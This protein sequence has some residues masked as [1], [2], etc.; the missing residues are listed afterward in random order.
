MG[1]NFFTICSL[2]YSTML[3]IIYFRRKNI[4]TLETS[5]YSKLVLINFMN[6]VLAILCYLTILMKD[7]LPF[8]NDLVSKSL[9][10]LFASWEFCFT[11]YL[12][13]ITRNQD[14]KLI[15]VTKKYKPILIVLAT[16]MI[17]VVFSLPLNYY[18]SNNIVYSYGPSANFIYGITA[19]L[20]VYWIITILRNFNILKSKKCIPVVL[21]IILALIAVAIQK[22][23]PGLLL[24]TAVETFITVLMF[25]TIENPDVKLLQELAKSKDI[26]DNANEEKTLFLYNITQEIRKAVNVVDD[27]ADLILMSEDVDEIRNSARELKNE[28]ARFTSKTNGIL[29]VSN[30]DSAN[31]KVYNSKYNIKLL[32]KEIVNLYEK[33]CINKNIEFRTSV[34]HNIPDMLLGDSINLKEVLMIVLDNS[35]KYTDS[36]YVELDI[37]TIIKKDVCRLIITIEDS[38]HGIKSED[39][40][41]YKVSNSSLSKAN[42]LITLMNGTMMILSDY[43]RGTRVKI[44]LDQKIENVELD[45]VNKYNSFFENIKIL[46]VDDSDASIK[47]VEKL[48]KGSNVTIDKAQTGVETLSKL[49][50]KEHYDIILLDEELAKIS[51][52]ELL[53]KMKNIRN[54][55]IP[56]VLLSKD[57]KHEYS[58]NYIEQGF[59]GVLIK[60]IKKDVLID[61][62]NKLI[63]DDKK[64]A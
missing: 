43:G 18:N 22:M 59:S 32:I 51:G 47:I 30:I 21:F 44:I 61:T 2:F 53:K 42:K 25:F 3:T 39:I 55:D 20:I 5:I 16:L 1:N 56:V 36:G 6:V 8:L 37:N 15:E 52:E 9:L 14:K 49:K 45:I 60:P 62:I 10:I 50:L 63:D 31:V 23:N 7:F 38:G 11:Y 57:N 4:K 12:L 27:Y 34:E 33:K 35:I 29:D 46:V 24:I 40:N 64:R 41:N 48:L 54:F 28:T 26:S 58:E 13:A 17:F 19:F